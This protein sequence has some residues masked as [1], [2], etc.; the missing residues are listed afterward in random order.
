MYALVGENPEC[1]QAKTASQG[2]PLSRS[3]CGQTHRARSRRALRLHLMLSSRHPPPHMQSSDKS[4]FYW[5][6]QFE[7]SQPSP[8]TVSTVIQDPVRNGEGR[9]AEL[10]QS[11]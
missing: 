2:G 6:Q 10:Y 9:A 1:A 7:S 8:V 4:K 3:P 11:H 5:V